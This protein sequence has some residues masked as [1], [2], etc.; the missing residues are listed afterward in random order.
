M[1]AT[2]LNISLSRELKEKVN[3][4]VKAHHYS[5]ASD[6]VRQLIRRDIERKQAQ[7]ELRALL[8]EGMKSGVSNKSPEQIFAE[9]RDYIHARL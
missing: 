1:G 8:A 4:Q 6:Y 9:L 7:E 3:E 5:N 2:S